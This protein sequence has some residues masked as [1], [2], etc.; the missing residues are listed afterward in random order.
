MPRLP[1]AI[2]LSF[3]LVSTSHADDWGQWLGPQRDGVWRE[4]GLLDTI[5]KDGLK[6]RWR[7]PVALGYAGP[8]VKD[9]KVFLMDRVIKEGAKNPANPF[10]RDKG[11]PGNERV[12]C[13]D[14]KTGKQLWAFEYDCPYTVS[15]AGGPRCTPAVDGNR[16]YDADRVYAYGTEGHLHCLDA[17]TGKKIWGRKMTENE[18]P[19][20]GYA[21]HPL[22]FDNLVYVT[23]ADP[24][25]ILFALNKMTGEVVWQ[26]IPTK[27]CGY[28]PPVLL[29]VA[30]K[31]QL[32]QWYPAG[33]TSLD[34]VT[35][36]VFWTVEQEPMKYGVTIVTPQL[37]R[38]PKLGDLLFVSSQYGGALMLKLDKSGNGDPTASIL[39][40]RVGKSDRTSDAIQTLMATPILRD[41]HIYGL[42]AKG[43]LRG[44]V[45][46]TGDRLWETFETTTYDA[47]MQSWA[48]S[49]M[50]PLGET[51][52]RTLFANEHGDL[53]IGDLT[54]A[55]FKQITKTHLLAP[56]N[57]DARRPTLWCHPALAN[58]SIYWRNDKELVCW[59][60]AKE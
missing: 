18:T 5:P 41:G 60:F 59:S 48:T 1:V 45:A 57:M 32:I 51:G 28:S 21:S 7:A 16:A 37:L 3:V 24:K 35:G 31:K 11:I 56:T 50:I 17:Q 36:K 40:K 30:G 58:R 49:F 8:A 19:V 52:S 29:D 33:V 46:A 15:Y 27:E 10:D 6:V 2:A 20:W 25:G 22:V 47:G 13:F 39:W 54:P 55:G 42:D 38:D 23:A 43:Q 9:G 14:E 4:D 26:A 12:L 44:L 34:P 53:I